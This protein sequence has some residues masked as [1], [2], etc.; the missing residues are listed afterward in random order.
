MARGPRIT[1][2]RFSTAG[3]CHGCRIRIF[4]LGDNRPG[5]DPTIEGIDDEGEPVDLTVPAGELSWQ[6]AFPDSEGGD[7]P[8]VIG[9]PRIDQPADGCQQ[10]R[11]LG[12]ATRTASLRRP[13]V[14]RHDW[15]G[16]RPR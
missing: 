6:L 15:N 4:G 16:K 7:P 1:L 3:S 2:K 9:R 5:D 13:S 14:V 10:Y 12:L 11:T 8:M